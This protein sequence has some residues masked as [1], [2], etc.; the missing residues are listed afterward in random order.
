MVGDKYISGAHTIGEAH[1]AA[2]RRRLFNFTGKGDAD[3][4]LNQERAAS[5]RKLCA[6]PND[7]TT[8]E[9]MDLNS[10]HNFDSHYY[11]N[12]LQKKALFHSDAALLSNPRTAKLA[13]KLQNQENFFNM[14]A[15]SMVRM[16]EIDVL[17]GKE[18]EI[19]KNCRLV[20]PF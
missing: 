4:T 19:R 7:N 20:N 11:V 8:T 6:N 5:L 1:C 2:F 16:G 12:L 18:G 9:D 3:P 10:G 17:T 14:F 15:Y 13:D